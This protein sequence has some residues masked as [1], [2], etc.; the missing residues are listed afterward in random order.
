MHVDIKLCNTVTPA[1]TETFLLHVRNVINLNKPRPRLAAKVQLTGRL[2]KL[3]K[4]FS[5]QNKKQHVQNLQI[6]NKFKTFHLDHVMHRYNVHTLHYITLHCIALHY[7]ALHYITTLHYITL[8][9]ITLH[10]ITLHYLALH[11]ITLLGIALHYITLHTIT[12]QYMCTYVCIYIYM[13]AYINAYIHTYIHMYIYI[14]IHTHLYL[15]RYTAYL[16]AI[17]HACMHAYLPT[18]LPPYLLR[19]DRPR[20][21][22]TQPRS[23]S[24]KRSIARAFP[25]T[26]LGQGRGIVP[27]SGLIRGV[28]FR[29]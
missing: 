27:F 3:S 18:S 6:V 13:Y 12:Y 16:Y 20:N 11:Y 1:T 15:F 7:I 14:Y 24:V 22:Y 21:T 23:L 5:F 19:A 8:H 4:T 29:V 26:C 17:M 25:R 28:G 10:Y 2:P 9:Y